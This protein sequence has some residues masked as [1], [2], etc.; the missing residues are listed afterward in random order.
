MSPQPYTPMSHLR[1]AAA[2][3]A[4]ARPVGTLCLFLLATLLA[5]TAP[6]AQAQTELAHITSNTYKFGY[7]VDIDGDWAVVGNAEDISGH[8]AGAVYLYQRDPHTLADWHFV[9]KLTQPWP[10]FSFGEA[11]AIDGDYL[12]VGDE[13]V[14]RWGIASGVV[15]VY[16]RNPLY[17]AGWE[18]V[19]ILTPNDAKDGDFFGTSVAIDGTTAVI[20]AT[21]IEGDTGPGKAYVFKLYNGTW[22][23]H[24]RLVASD[25]H[26]CAVEIAYGSED[27]DCEFGEGVAVDGGRV[28]VFNPWHKTS[29]DP[30]ELYQQA[31]VFEPNVLTPSGWSEAAI[32]RPSG[33]VKGDRQQVAVDGD[34]VLVGGYLFT[35]QNGVW[36]ETVINRYAESAALEGDRALLGVPVDINQNGLYAGAAYLYEFDPLTSTWAEAAVLYASN[37]EPGDRLG[38][39]VALDGNRALVAALGSEPVGGQAYLFGL[40]GLSLSA[41][42]DVLNNKAEVVAALTNWTTDS[43]AHQVWEVVTD[44]RGQQSVG[45]PVWVEL[46]PESASEPFVLGVYSPETNGTYRVEV[47]AGRYPDEVVAEAATSFEYEGGRPLSARAEAA[48]P[49]VASLSASPNPFHGRASLRFFVPAA[50]EVSLRVYD[51][52][53]REVA[54]LEAGRLDAGAYERAFEAA[55]LASGVYVARLQV[56]GDVEV[57]RLTLLR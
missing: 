9:A 31:Y 12:F 25:R 11:V 30:F 33:Y 53:G 52:V 46:E 40:P 17:T 45:R 14:S 26:D 55:G 32:L 38:S 51:L 39:R 2:L 18:L 57:R 56:G 15:Y 23:Q 5:L 34:R 6:P 24:A 48:D 47:F 28:V 41:Y 13:Y 37:G 4:S 36:S 1:F 54:V 16:R 29:E 8:V 44:P 7:A 49:L 42:A 3:P 27:N 35:L 21:Q 22:Y 20:G 43:Q 19:Q 50:A 10:S